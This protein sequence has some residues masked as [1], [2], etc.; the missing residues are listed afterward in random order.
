[1]AQFSFCYGKNENTLRK[2]RG[3]VIDAW[4][5]VVEKSSGDFSLFIPAVDFDRTYAEISAGIGAVSGYVRCDMGHASL[6][7]NSL[8]T[9]N[10]RNLVRRISK[11]GGWP[12][13]EE[14]TGS[15]A[16][17][18]FSSTD[19]KIVICNDLLG[20][21]PLYVSFPGKNVIG[22]TSLVVLGNSVEASVDVVGVLQ[23]IHPYYPCCGCNF[24]RR[25]LIEQMDRLLP[26]ERMVINTD[27]FL[28]QS[29]FDNTLCN[30]LVDAE[31]DD[32]ANEVWGN[33]RKETSLAIG[34][35][36]TFSV[37]LSGGWDSRLVLGAIPG[38]SKNINCL[39]YGND[40]VYEVEVA[41]RCAAALNAGFQNYS[42][43]GN[44]FPTRESFEGIVKKTEFSYIL[45]WLSMMGEGK[46][47][48]GRKGLIL[49]GDLC[50]GL[51]GKGMKSL[52]TRNFKIKNFAKSFLGNPIVFQKSDEKSF[53]VWKKNTVKSILN[54]LY[55]FIDELSPILKKKCT[56]ELIEYEVRKDL[57]LDFARIQENM[58]E[59]SSM[60]DEL[61][62]WFHYTRFSMAS[63]LLLL[64]NSY[65]AISPPMSMGFLRF[66]SKVH[67]ARRI[68]SNLIHAIIK[69]PA[70]DVLGKIPSAQVPWISS[71]SPLFIKEIV[72][73][74]RAILD[75]S[76]MKK[77]MRN[78]KPDGRQHFVEWHNYIREY[79]RKETLSNVR[80]LFSGDW[81]QGD[82]CVD[83]VK[84]R[85]N[86][87][88]WPH[89]NSD[90]AIPASVSIILDSVN[91]LK[92]S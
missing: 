36:E 40:D 66:I 47:A 12:L 69:Q 76:C 86:L 16:A 35:E 4:G 58:P 81:V 88:L 53:L 85:A 57:E 55:R 83:I 24:G 80:K 7:E 63:Q 25:T 49:L 37:A 54:E 62:T 46:D 17:V 10:N 71:R 65:H 59:F 90:I 92:V 6:E 89:I 87:D 44:Y 33:Y 32:V 84:G 22:G 5:K 60:Y 70:F 34:D 13:G 2:M 9:I 21:I 38:H 78:K 52:H 48:G 15:F 23:R 26:G 11:T 19:R 39:T 8:D 91:E 79:R 82:R 14:W 74:V 1:M 45:S 31:L 68:H 67:P 61:F 3:A 43:E 30:G 29:D 64:N 73:G 41:S 28:S 42:M 27:N 50:D 75:D 18:S 56:K 77:T 72:W 51:T 20:Y